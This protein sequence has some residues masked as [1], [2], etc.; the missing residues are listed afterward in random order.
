[1]GAT[2]RVVGE[3]V[4]V[5]ATLDEYHRALHQTAGVMKTSAKP[6]S[7]SWRT[8]AHSVEF[9][10]AEVR[11]VQKARRTSFPWRKAE[12]IPSSLTAIATQPRSREA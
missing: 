6:I 2:H 10:T 9:A 1:M 5:A 7:D 3:E 12:R 11:R 4:P 8:Y